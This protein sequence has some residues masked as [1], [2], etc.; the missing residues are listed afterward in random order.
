MKTGLLLILILLLT[1]TLHA[2]A[3]KKIAIGNSGCS[4]YSYCNSVFE[5]SLSEDSSRVFTG[6]CVNDE[7]TYGV[8]CVKLL[9]PVA[10]LQM[11]EDLLIA[12][13]DFLKNNFEIK[14]AVG[15]GKGHQLNNNEKTRGILDYWT[16]A[17]GNQWKIKAWT[18]GKF[19]G[20]LYGYSKK[21]LPENKLDAF[22]NSFRMPGM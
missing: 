5:S 16:D 18:D 3:L 6:E 14:K 2:Q 9:N 20:F 8:I 11:A 12:Y 1:N 19:I 7:V 22:L 4:V 15:Y 21:V 13:A 10:D 17:E